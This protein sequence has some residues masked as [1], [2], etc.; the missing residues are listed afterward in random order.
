MRVVNI[1]SADH[2]LF[3]EAWKIYSYSFPLFERRNLEPQKRA[4]SQSECSMDIFLTDE[5][6]DVVGFM[7]FWEFDDS[8]YLEHFAVAENFRNGGIGGR[9][10][11]LF[12]EAH[13]PKRVILDVDLP[14]DE[15]SKR[16]IGFYERHG[17]FVNEE[18]SHPHPNLNDPSAEY[19]EL[20][21]MSHGGKLSDNDYK[22]FRDR[23]VNVICLNL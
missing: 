2:R 6:D 12:V 1:K 16:R 5:G 15:I 9:M 13:K 18:R 19:F 11:D 22:Q 4:L 10:L 17:F 3:E 23:F 14:E 21:I 8:I 7:L 20:R